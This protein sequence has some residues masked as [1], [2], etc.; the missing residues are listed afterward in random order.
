M[1]IIAFVTIVMSFNG[2][3]EVTKFVEKELPFFVQT[4]SEC[5][6]IYDQTTIKQIKM[7]LENDI[8]SSKGSV[9]RIEVRCGA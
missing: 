5:E 7:T 3:P 6:M 2:G 8:S 1:K 9:K 4:K